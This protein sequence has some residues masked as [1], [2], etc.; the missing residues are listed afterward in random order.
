MFKKSQL[1]MAIG[2]LTVFSSQALLAQSAIESEAIEAAAE[3]QAESAVEEVVVTGSRI[4]RDVFSSSSPME[5]IL[6]ETAEVQIG[7]AHV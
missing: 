2:A 1:S 6:M 3:E 7:R 5:V 4:S